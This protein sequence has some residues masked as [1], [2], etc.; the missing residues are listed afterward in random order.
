M[1][2]TEAGQE[3]TKYARANHPSKESLYDT[4]EFTGGASAG[5]EKSR[6]AAIETLSMLDTSSEKPFDK[7]TKA[8]SQLFKTP[9][10]LI[11]LVADPSRVWFKSCLGPF[12]SCVNRDGSWCNYVLVPPT[13]EVLITEDASRDTRLAHNPYVAGSPYIKFY[14]GAPLV[15]SAGERYGTL[16]V[17]DLVQRVFTAELYSVLINFAALA[18][19]EIERNKP[20]K[21]KASSATMNDVERNRYLDM[22][23]TGAREG[24]LMLDAREYEWP[25]VYANPAFEAL[26]GLEMDDLAGAEFWDLYQDA[27]GRS[28]AD[29]V[30]MLGHGKDFVAT[31]YCVASETWVT[32]KFIPATSDRLAPSKAT[33][34]PSWVPSVDGN[35][36]LGIDV[37]SDKIHSVA[38]RDTNV[39]QDVK[40]F[41]FAIVIDKTV[42]ESGVSGYDEMAETVAPSSTDDQDFASTNASS[43]GDYLS[44][45]L[46][47]RHIKLGPLLGSGSF[48][49]VYRGVTQD[50]VTVA[51]K[52]I[53]CR[54]RESGVVEEQ[55]N[56]VR[57]SEDFDHPAVVKTLAHGHSTE[58][59]QGNELNVAWVVQELC[60]MG[61]LID[62]TER[63]WLRVKRDITAPPDMNVILPTLIDIASGMAYV[64]SKSVIHA[65]L[66]GRNVLLNK[67]TTQV[68]GFQAKVCDFGLSR[69]SRIGTG[70]RTDTMGTVTHMAPSLLIH[71]K[72]YPAADV[73][74][75]GVIGW[76]SFF[77]KRCYAGCNA[78]QIIMTVVDNQSLPWPTDV[79][80]G[81]LSLMKRCL[82]F[83]YEK[84]PTFADT[85][86]VLE[87]LCAQG[88]TVASDPSSME[89]KTA[90][91]GAV[92]F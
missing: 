90:Y 53:D 54:G 12:G 58:T 29:V 74:A 37:D 57:M 76:E 83:E 49:K 91:V 16:C 39:V 44:P 13:P 33:A 87:E 61:T 66:N 85:I 1:V 84:R 7:I 19:E 72:L 43:Y 89:E 38:D 3:E 14:A 77:G 86:P 63:G 24:V 28:K 41:W 88:L 26:S 73:W 23:L 50:R 40:T 81:Y 27:K 64:H 17:V 92:Q 47:L 68:H 59:I 20:L 45:P 31:L 80:E 5:G 32:L 22:S 52:I 10:S 56:E 15:G 30:T 6:Y 36:N 34:I 42:S 8:M 65:D 9:V 2:T 4:V 79:P 11:T 78:P 35:S 69:T 21:E 70:I 67:S 82:S 46:S 71:Q 18:V 75:F 60:D 55:L 51:V 48:G 25:I 62:A